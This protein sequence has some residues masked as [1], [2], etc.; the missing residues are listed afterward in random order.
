MKTVANFLG[1]VVTL[2]IAVVLGEQVHL[3]VGHICSAT[4]IIVPDES[5]EVI[6]RGSSD[7]GLHVRDVVRCQYGLS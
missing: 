3:D 2:E 1:D 5:V 4:Q 6:R 7:V